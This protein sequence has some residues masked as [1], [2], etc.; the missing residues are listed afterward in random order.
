MDLTL[1]RLAVRN[2]W[3]RPRGTAPLLFGAATATAMLFALTVVY[4]SGV[5]AVEHAAARLGAD[6]LVVPEAYAGASD[7]AGVILAGGTSRDLLRVSAVDELR[8][9]P[10][11][12]AASP[13]LFIVSAELACCSIANTSLVGFDPATDFTIA[14]WIAETLGRPLG[15]KEIV[16][17]SEILPEPGGKI[18][19][20]GTVFT[21]AGKLE[22]TGIGY[23]D[24]SV[25][26]PMPGARAMIDAQNVSGRERLDIP[27]GSVSAVLLRFKDGVSPAEA[28]LGIEYRHPGL[29]VILSQAVVRRVRERMMAPLR[30]AVPVGILSWAV[31][32]VLVGSM[33][34]VMLA[35]RRREMGVMRALGAT[36]G[37]IRGMLA[38]EVL[39]MSIACGA[40]GLP[41]GYGLAFGLPGVFGTLSHP[42]G[43]G[44]LSALAVGALGVCVLSWGV[45][46]ALAIRRES[47]LGPFDAMR[48]D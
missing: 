11:V 1:G 46:V 18:M 15:D 39:I 30:G 5:R 40:M 44:V 13:H 32:F 42:P 33:Y 8:G 19:F 14:P 24:R 34:A 23:I 25:F 29:S 28:A 37:F 10:V 31:T 48:Q 36:G 41:L 38:M 2:L 17:G 45:A 43:V 26:I 4:L 35:E 47:R 9:D 27:A 21:I 3:R 20:F 12:E 16:V 7:G 22:P 6:A